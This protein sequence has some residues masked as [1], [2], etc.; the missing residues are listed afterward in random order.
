M[1]DHR[2][3]RPAPDGS[4]PLPDGHVVPQ[5]PRPPLPLATR[6]VVYGVLCVAL[7]LVAVAIGVLR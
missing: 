3:G 1:P 6:E 2:A 4:P 5:P 7:V